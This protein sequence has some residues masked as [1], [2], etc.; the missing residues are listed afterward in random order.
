VIFSLTAAVAMV[1]CGGDSQ[2]RSSKRHTA[3]PHWLGVLPLA[4]GCHNLAGAG[5]RAEVTYG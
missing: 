3:N 4:V 2:Q 5:L 1:T